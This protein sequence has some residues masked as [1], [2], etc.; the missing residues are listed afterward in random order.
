MLTKKFQELEE[1]KGE[2][3]GGAVEATPEVRLGMLGRVRDAG[4]LAAPTPAAFPTCAR[5]VPSP[6]VIGGFL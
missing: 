3:E 6:S 4:T 5:T 2:E 1:T